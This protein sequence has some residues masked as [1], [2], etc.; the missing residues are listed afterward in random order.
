MRC[1]SSPRGLLQY[2]IFLFI[3]KVT[4]VSEKPPCWPSQCLS[5]TVKINPKS[6]S[7]C[8]QNAE[9]SFHQKKKWVAPQHRKVLVFVLYLICRKL[10]VTLGYWWLQANLWSNPSIDPW[11]TNGDLSLLTLGQRRYCRGHHF[12]SHRIP[13]WEQSWHRAMLSFIIWSHCYQLWTCRRAFEP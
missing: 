3:A 9:T 5:N 6:W 4:P 2:S 7:T 12:N 8:R 1:T 11:G 10:M 13:V